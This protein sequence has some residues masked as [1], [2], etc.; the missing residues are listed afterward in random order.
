MG[1]RASCALGPLRLPP[2]WPKGLLRFGIIEAPSTW[3]WGHLALWD[4]RGPY[5]VG[6]GA[7]FA[8]APPRR[9]PQGRGD[10]FHV[11]IIEAP[12]A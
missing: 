3:A 4:H 9:P 2:C 10:L 6:A 5:C 7:S 1:V 8:L 11:W 12:S